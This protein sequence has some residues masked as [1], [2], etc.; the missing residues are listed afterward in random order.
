VWWLTPIAL[1]LRRL[2][3]EDLG[4]KANLLGYVLSQKK[5]KLR[6]ERIRSER[7]N[8]RICRAGMKHLFFSFD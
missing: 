8:F 2:R 6:K 3:Q 7:W 5:K 1:A 4:F